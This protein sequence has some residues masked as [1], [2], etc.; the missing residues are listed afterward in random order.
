MDQFGHIF[1]TR[2]VPVPGGVLAK[3]F[4][5]TPASERWEKERRWESLRIRTEGRLLFMRRLSASQWHKR[6]IT[7]KWKFY[8]R[9]LLFIL[10]CWTRLFLF[11]WRRDLPPDKFN[12]TIY[13]AQDDAKTSLRTMRTGLFIF[14]FYHNSFHFCKIT[15]NFHF[16]KSC[17][18][19]R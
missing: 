10:V 11:A 1:C 5:L 4:L 6:K 8:G 2:F 3:I 18:T 9:R 14:R 16:G 17:S 12:Y 7:P 13:S 19:T 15:S